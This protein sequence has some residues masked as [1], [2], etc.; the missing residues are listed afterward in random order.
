VENE[1]ALSMVSRMKRRS[2]MARAC[3]AGES[4]IFG[5]GEG[6]G[7]MAPIYRE[8][9]LIVKYFVH[10]SLAPVAKLAWGRDQDVVKQPS[11]GV[12]SSIEPPSRAGIRDR[13]GSRR[14]ML[15]KDE[16]GPIRREC[17]DGGECEAGTRPASGSRGAPLQRP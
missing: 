9:R 14:A 13:H 3:K 1:E 10:Q 2:A 6:P 4:E 5:R 11:T 8:G 12:T 15:A 16:I 17:C 7:G